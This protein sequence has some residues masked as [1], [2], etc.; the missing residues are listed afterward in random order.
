MPDQQESLYP[1]CENCDFYD[2]VTESAQRCR[3][4]KFTMP[5][6][7]WQIVCRDWIH[8]G[9]QADFGSLE[10]N[11]LHYYAAGSED[12]TH[13]PLRR[14][15]DLKNTMVS[16]RLRRDK[17][18][19]WVIYLGAHSSRHFPSPGTHVN[20]MISRRSCKFQIAN[21]LREMAK[22]MIPQHGSWQEV[23]HTQQSF[24]LFSMEHHQLVY[25]WLNS[26]MDID[27]Y[28]E[29]SFV[30]SVFAFMEVGG[31]NSEYT[32]YADTL[33]YRQYLLRSK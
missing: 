21:P 12:I 11:T 15:S 14:F 2:R 8:G 17:E 18:Y 25:S 28:I 7:E 10:A 26:F 29:E 20:V 3:K 24:M 30:P 16:V 23:R 13:A 32:L 4:H 9:E 27:R 6:V 22:E 31:K 33:A 19:G 5:E 1:Q